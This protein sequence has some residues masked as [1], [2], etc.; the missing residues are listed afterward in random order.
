MGAPCVGRVH[1]NN[2]DGLAPGG[3]SDIKSA[4]DRRAFG[5][6]HLL[7]WEILIS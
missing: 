5:R 6:L 4:L 7:D 2:V 1:A 3:L